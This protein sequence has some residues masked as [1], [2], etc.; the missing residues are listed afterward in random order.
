MF[1]TPHLNGTVCLSIT[2]LSTFT[3]DAV[4]AWYPKPR[5]SFTDLN[6]L[7]RLAKSDLGRVNK[8]MADAYWLMHT[9]IH[10]PMMY[11]SMFCK[12]TGTFLADYTVSH[13][14]PEHGIFTA[15]KT[16]KLIN[17]EFIFYFQI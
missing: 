8:Y 12:N 5:S 11:A 3:M 7:V 15:V 14:R 16:S 1:L 10:T 9:L 6:N 4:Y 17:C 13:L 2:D